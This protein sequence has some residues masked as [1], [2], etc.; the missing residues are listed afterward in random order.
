[1]TFLI[2]T[3]SGGGPNCTR[4]DCMTTHNGPGSTTLAYYQPIYNKQGVNVNPDMNTTTQ[5]MRCL[6]CGKTWTEQ[7]QNGIRTCVE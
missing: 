2:E 4:E 6:T 1:M 5:P 7:W 3:L